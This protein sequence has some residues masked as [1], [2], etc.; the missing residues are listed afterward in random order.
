[1]E[2]ISLSYGFYIPA[3]LAFLYLHRT[4]DNI[5]YVDSVILFIATSLTL[6]TAEFIDNSV[7]LIP[8][9]AFAL[10]FYL[11]KRSGG[12]SRAMPA[13]VILTLCFISLIIPDVCGTIHFGKGKPGVLGGDGITDAL[14]KP[15]FFAVFYFLLCAIIGWLDK[16]GPSHIFALLQYHWNIKKVVEEQE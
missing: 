2:N 16:K 4:S 8:F 1:M 9:Y 15:V 12:Q 10:F 3:V 7:K 11:I 14:F 5:G 6:Y 13:G